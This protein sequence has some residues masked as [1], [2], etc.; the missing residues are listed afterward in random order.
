MYEK[1]GHAFMNDSA[2]SLELKI[3]MFGEDAGQ[4]D[5][6]AVKLGWKRFFAFFGEHLKGTRAA[7]GGG[8]GADA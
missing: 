5:P 7:V 8:G 6:E 4:H 3:K 1:V 2:A